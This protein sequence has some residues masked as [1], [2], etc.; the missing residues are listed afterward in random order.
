VKPA[1]KGPSNDNKDTCFGLEKMASLVA[2]RIYIIGIFQSFLSGCTEFLEGEIGE[3][4][5]G[6]EGKGGGKAR[7]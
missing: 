6:G 7:G 2:A 4:L 5:G 3:F 1:Q